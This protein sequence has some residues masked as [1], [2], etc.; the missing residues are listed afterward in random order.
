MDMG[1]WQYPGEFDPQHWFGFI[2]RVINTVT[3]QHYIGKKQFQSTRRKVV[4]NRKARKIVKS[5]S[6][7]RQYTSSSTHLN[8]AIQVQGHDQFVFL[9]ERLCKSKASLHYSEVEYQIN[10][11]VLR[12]T[13]PNGDK[14]YLNKMIANMRFIPPAPT[15]DEITHQISAYTTHHHQNTVNRYLDNM[16]SAD[17]HTWAHLYRLPTPS[18][19][20]VSEWQQRDGLGE[21]PTIHVVAPATVVILVCPHCGKTGGNAIKRHHFDNCKHAHMSVK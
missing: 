15:H 20:T 11:D 9:I 6:G 14:K 17:K 19:A 2:Y 13:L 7:W 12:A 5:D 1:H 8:D 18:L 16:A 4:K 21:T 10:E 3:G